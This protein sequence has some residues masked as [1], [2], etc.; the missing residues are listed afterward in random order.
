MSTRFNNDWLDEH[1][2]PEFSGWVRPVKDTPGKAF[3]WKCHKTINLSNMGKRSLLSHMK[4]E[5][6]TLH[7]TSVNT[8]KIGAFYK[9]PSEINSN[10]GNSSVIVPALSA[11][12]SVAEMPSF[13][14]KESASISSYVSTSEV[15]KC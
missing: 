4:G 14:V 7:G 13:A 12:S 10:P 2:Y 11:T 6:H 15:T 5:T 9:T 8:P 3:C 1:L